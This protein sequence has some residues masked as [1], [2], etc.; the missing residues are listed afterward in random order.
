V[1]PGEAARA[2]GVLVA[3]SNLY[4]A[5]DALA[6]AGVGPVSVTNPAYVFEPSSPAAE[7]LSE[8]LGL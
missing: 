2:N 1:A 6:R 5:A 4:A 8:A 3:A 7:S